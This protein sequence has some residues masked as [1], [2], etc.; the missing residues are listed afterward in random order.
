G[1]HWA[2]RMMMQ[3]SSTSWQTAASP[4][5]KM[6]CQRDGL[7]S[8]VR[9]ETTANLGN[10][11]D[12]MPGGKAKM[13]Y[14]MAPCFSSKSSRSKCLPLPHFTASIDSPTQVQAHNWK[15]TPC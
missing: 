10:E 9:R 3:P 5:R 12:K 14:L 15:H 11:K 4:Q 8:R 13:V 1:L 6:R 2:N 7:R